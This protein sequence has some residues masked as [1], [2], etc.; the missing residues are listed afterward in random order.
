MD[1]KNQYK[2]LLANLELGKKSKYETK[3][4]PN[5]L[6]IVPRSLNRDTLEIKTQFYGFDVWH[7]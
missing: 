4:N 2:E 3:Y 7:M 1:N 5:L 6:Q